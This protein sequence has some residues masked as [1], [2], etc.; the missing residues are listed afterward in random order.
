MGRIFAFHPDDPGS[1]PGQ[2]IKVSLH[3]TT[4]CCLAKIRFGWVQ[5]LPVWV[6]VSIRGT[7]FHLYNTYVEIL[8]PKVAGIGGEAFG[9]LGHEG[10][11]FMNGTNT[12]T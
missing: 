4:H 7:Q 12:L 3:D 6:Q 9:I 1:I 8:P 5:A 10:R 11:A 2:G